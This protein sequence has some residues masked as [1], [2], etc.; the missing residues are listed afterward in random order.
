MEKKDKVKSEVKKAEKVENKSKK[1]KYE[2]NVT[3]FQKFGRMFRP[4]M[5]IDFTGQYKD[6]LEQ[7]LEEG[8]IRIKK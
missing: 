2:M 7:W 8:K 5:N 4:E 1:L 3:G 6:Y